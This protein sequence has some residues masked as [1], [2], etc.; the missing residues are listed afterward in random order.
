MDKSMDAQSAIRTNEH[1]DYSNIIRK[2]IIATVASIGV[3][4]GIAGCSSNSGSGTEGLNNGVFSNYGQL[5]QTQTGVV[6]GMYPVKV[7]QTQGGTQTVVGAN[8]NAIGNVVGD[9]PLVN[10]NS[11]FSPVANLFGG[12]GSSLF[13]SAVQ[14]QYHP[15]VTKGVE[16]LVKFDGAPSTQTGYNAQAGTVNG[17]TIGILQTPS[18]AKQITIGE[19]VVVVQN[20]QTGAC[21]IFP[22]QSQ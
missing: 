21:T 4:A 14:Q 18:Q 17:K 3:V 2:G 13:G 12:L 9:I 1:K 16:V 5:S 10:S 7:S 8:S 20:K 11:F 22:E 15:N 6:Q 19:K